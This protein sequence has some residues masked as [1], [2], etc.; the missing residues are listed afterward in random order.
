[1]SQWRTL[2]QTYHVTLSKESDEIISVPEQDNQTRIIPLIHNRVIS[3]LG[4][5][6]EKFLQGQLT[7]D[8]RD[9]SQLG[10]RLGAHCNTKGGMLALYRVMAVEGGFWL[11]MHQDILDGGLKNIKKYIMFSKAEAEDQS[12]QIVG[13]G[14]MGPGASTLVEKLFDK[15]PSETDKAIRAGQM[16][17]VK[18]PGDRYEIWLPAQE[19]EAALQQ[20]TRLAPL[21]TTQDWILEEIKAG[22]PDVRLATL[23]SFIPQMTNLQA[24]K[25][26][27][28]NKGCYTGQEIVARL[29][30]RGK[31]NKPMY[32]AQ[33]NT[34]T[35]P[36]AG[37]KLHT[38]E[39]QNVGQIVL[40]SR[41][42][43]SEVTL[44]AVINKTQVDEKQSI[45]LDSPEGIEGAEGPALK[46][47]ELPYEL[48]PELFLSKR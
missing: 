27:S 15:V 2:L 13:L 19:V 22:I 38:T 44:L 6:A 42:G 10:S 29:Q 33:I 4:P 28:F 17:A 12:E 18:V 43:D 7:C 23:E 40:A 20:L 8:M 21:G 1:M 11:R 31:L 16:I 48:D 47:L 30:H 25:G 39:K 26:V 9:T 46:I 41:S 14:L 36:Q 34:D 37:D 3:I 5:D 35:L 45:Y 24:L 32:L